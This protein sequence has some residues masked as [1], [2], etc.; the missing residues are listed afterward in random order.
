MCWEG[1]MPE[2]SNSQLLVQCLAEAMETMAFVS[3]TPNEQPPDSLPEALLT[4]IDFSDPTR[5]TIELLA[6]GAF[7]R[8]V[9]AQL[10]GIEP[11]SQELTER[12]GDVL[13]E[14]LNV[15]CGLILGHS[16]DRSN[17]LMTVPRVEPFDATGWSGQGWELLDAEG[18]TLAVRIKEGR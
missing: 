6:P 5:R 14:I 17:C 9:A 16:P 8:Q 11:D 18:F 2:T 15:T 4:A 12:G 13:K 1:N 10:L 7:G 3:V